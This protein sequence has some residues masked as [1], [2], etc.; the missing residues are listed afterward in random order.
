[1]YWYRELF[2]DIILSVVKSTPKEEQNLTTGSLWDIRCSGVAQLYA[3]IGAASTGAGALSTGMRGR[4]CWKALFSAGAS[5]L[6]IGPCSSIVS[7]QIEY[8]AGFSLAPA[9][10]LARWHS[11]IAPHFVRLG[12]IHSTRTG[13]GRL[14]AA[15]HHN[16]K[17]QTGRLLPHLVATKSPTT[18]RTSYD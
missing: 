1:M 14:C 11:C 4:C 3:C 15:Q 9:S 16:Q 10:M 7:R 5:P 2:D 8:G 17:T 13:W 6:G 12:S 18:V